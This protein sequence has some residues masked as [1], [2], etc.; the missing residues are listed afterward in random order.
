[1]PVNNHFIKMGTYCRDDA[2]RNSLTDWPCKAFPDD[3]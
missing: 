2:P 3:F 1:M